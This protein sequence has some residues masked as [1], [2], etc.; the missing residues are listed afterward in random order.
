MKNFTTKL[1]TLA[2]AILLI[3]IVPLVACQRSGNDAAGTNN[4]SEG[5]G[6][7]TESWGEYEG[8]DVSLYTLTNKNGVTA[9]VTNWGAVLTELHTKDKDGNLAD[10]ITGYE[11]L[12]KWLNAGG[13]GKAN[14]DYFGCTVGRYCN[15]I[16][17]AKFSL[18]G[19]D[20]TLAANNDP[21]HLHGGNVGWDKK[22]WDGEIVDHS[23][24]Q[25]VKLT[26][27]SADG[28]EGYPGTV[29]AEIVYILTDDDELRLEFS[30][31]T[32]KATP[33]SMTNHSYF[34]LAGQ[35]SG[36]I[37]DHECKIEAD[38]FTVFDETGIPTGE[39]KPVAGTVFDFTKSTR[40]GDRMDKL[41]ANEETGSVGGYDQNY[42]L[43]DAKIANPV[44]AGTFYEPTSGRVLK[45]LTTEV[46]V[47]L[48]SGNYLDGSRVG[49]DG[50]KYEQHFAFCFEPQFHPDSPNQADFP[51]S[52]LKPGE[53]YSQI[54]VFKFETK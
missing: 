26:L 8:K 47:Q 19:A 45:V 37:L 34:N 4:N 27:T 39:I 22:V 18:D 49:K 40:I 53:T 48:Y 21:S 46:G 20:Y 11:T 54:T 15:R 12:D 7:S 9:K 1:Q 29:E 30:A 17:G 3:S 36:T 31:T 42:V 23:E 5:N 6:V 50:K 25:A 28:D 14:P 44:L 33:I 41:P 13:P 35:G 32:D 10:I 2:F 16:S 52:I 38:R 24:G 51:S 43:R